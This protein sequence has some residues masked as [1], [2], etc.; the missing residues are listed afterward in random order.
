MTLLRP[1]SAS[2]AAPARTSPGWRS[3][4]LSRS[5][6][7][8]SPNSRSPFQR[9]SRGPAVRCAAYARSPPNQ[10][11]QVTFDP[12]WPAAILA[13]VSCPFGHD[14]LDRA[15]APAT[16]PDSR[17][18]S[19]RASSTISGTPAGLAQSVERLTC[20]HEVASSILAPGSIAALRNPLTARYET[21]SYAAFSQPSNSASIW[22]ASVIR[23]R[24]SHWQTIRSHR[25]TGTNQQTSTGRPRPT[26]IP[27]QSPHSAPSDQP[28]S[29]RSTHWAERHTGTR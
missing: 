11:T 14:T 16:S 1:P 5:G 4:S 18:V 25:R 27:E 15:A 12:F 10:L 24:L 6:S 21:R 29:S 2:I 28:H 9:S 7:G 17:T 8:A 19:R 26:Q 20:N 22:L 23:T 3:A 13:G